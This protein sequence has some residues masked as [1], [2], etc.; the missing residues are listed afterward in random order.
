MQPIV[1]PYICM[2]F[3][4]SIWQAGF[5]LATD[6]PVWAADHCWPTGRWPDTW[7]DWGR[8]PGLRE[9][10]VRGRSAAAWTRWPGSPGSGSCAAAPSA[11]FPPVHRWSPAAWSYRW[12]N[13]IIYAIN[14]KPWLC[15]CVVK[16]QN[17]QWTDNCCSSIRI[18][19]SL[20]FI[21]SQLCQHAY[22]CTY[23]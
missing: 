4:Y 13:K 17:L 3:T 7:S 2:L 20:V 6:L 18:S 16:Y 14:D 1:L 9:S 8:I 12:A 10:G 23:I 5:E 21:K 22:I 15:F 19:S 11:M